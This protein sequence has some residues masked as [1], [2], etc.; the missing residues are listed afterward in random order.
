MA[1]KRYMVLLK[2][3]LSVGVEAEHYQ[4]QKRSGGIGTAEINL[5]SFTDG[6]REVCMV[7]L[8]ELVAVVSEN[9]VWRSPANIN[10]HAEETPA[11]A[12]SRSVKRNGATKPKRNG[13]RR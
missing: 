12:R 7:P 13:R 4:P 10:G 3:G 11:T 9:N 2:G 8:A 5:M 6:E 1:G